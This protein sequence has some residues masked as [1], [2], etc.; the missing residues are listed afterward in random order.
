M[1]KG[2]P[3]CILFFNK[4]SPELGMEFRE[5]N[6][7]E[8]VW[9]VFHPSWGT[10]VERESLSGLGG[11]VQAGVLEAISRWS[12]AATPP[13]TD[14]GTQRPR[15]G[16]KKSP[17]VSCIPSGCVVR[18]KPETGGIARASLGHRL[19]ALKPLA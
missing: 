7:W 14:E 17:G 18:G 11:I 1:R 3:D 9:D 12:S 10:L 13:D 16:S 6:G 4:P 2:E 15:E 5:I 19:I 8:N